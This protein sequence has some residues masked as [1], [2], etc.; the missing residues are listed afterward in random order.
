MYLSINTHSQVPSPSPCFSSPAPLSPTRPCAPPAGA[1]VHAMP[2]ATGSPRGPS[3]AEAQECRTQASPGVSLPALQGAE[4]GSHPKGQGAM[5][6]ACGGD[7][8]GTCH[9]GPPLLPALHPVVLKPWGAGGRGCCWRIGVLGRRREWR[10]SPAA[11]LPAAW[12]PS[13]HLLSQSLWCG[14]SVVGKEFF[15]ENT[16]L[17]CRHQIIGLVTRGNGLIQFILRTTIRGSQGKL[18]ELELREVE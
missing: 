15:S 2:T 1:R 9:P 16:G 12:S 14:F 7:L 10:V 4:K 18:R 5:P 17:S 6:P 3:P 8:A 11:C 13:C